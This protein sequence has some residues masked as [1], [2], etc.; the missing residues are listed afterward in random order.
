LDNNHH[1]FPAINPGFRHQRANLASTGNQSIYLV[2]VILALPL[3]ALFPGLCQLQVN[4]SERN[5]FIYISCAHHISDVTRY[6]AMDPGIV[7]D[8]FHHSFHLTIGICSG[9]ARVA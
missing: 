8:F 2:I 5:S 3:I 6:A 1:G 7:A 9:R 4:Q